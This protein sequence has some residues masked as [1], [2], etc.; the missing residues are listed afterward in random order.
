VERDMQFTLPPFS[1][2]TA[3]HPLAAIAS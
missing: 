3:I 2:V 1:G